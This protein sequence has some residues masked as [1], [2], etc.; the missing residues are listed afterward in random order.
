MK[1]NIIISFLLILI[2]LLGNGCIA[3]K[4]FWHP[5]NRVRIPQK[6][7]VNK[8]NINTLFWNQMTESFYLQVRL[9]QEQELIDNRN[10]DKDN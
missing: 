6:F 1:H 5:D 4:E 3:N 8:N 9:K 2:F 10:K 7:I